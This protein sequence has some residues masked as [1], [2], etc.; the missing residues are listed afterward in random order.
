MATKHYFCAVSFETKRPRFLFV[1]LAEGIIKPKDADLVLT[2]NSV[3]HD[4]ILLNK[5]VQMIE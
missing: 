3:E 2:K 5:M 4:E 1:Q